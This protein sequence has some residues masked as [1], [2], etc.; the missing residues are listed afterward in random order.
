MDTYTGIG[1]VISIIALVVS[2]ASHK[3]TK[4]I[5]N[6]IQLQNN[7][8]DLCQKLQKLI[9]YGSENNLIIFKYEIEN[10]TFYDK[11]SIESGKEFNDL[12]K[13]LCERIIQLK[14]DYVELMETF[15]FL[16]IQSS[17]PGLSKE[18]QFDAW[19]QDTVN[20]YFL[21]LDKYYHDLDHIFLLT[22][23]AQSGLLDSNANQIIDAFWDN[24]IDIIKASQAL[25][26]LKRRMA[27]CFKMLSVREIDTFNNNETLISS[28]KKEMYSFVLDFG[29]DDAINGT[30]FSKIKKLCPDFG[31]QYDEFITEEKK[32]HITFLNAIR[33]KATKRK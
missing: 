7:Y 14:S 18:N 24:V 27:G 11:D 1:I 16:F 17:I 5:N 32:D 23:T 8:F 4:A 26:P 25:Q 21:R 30:D 22:R 13:R 20:T 12:K 2:I 6:Q 33:N 28:I 31:D 3:T 15:D 19:L 29:I 10:Y 9:S